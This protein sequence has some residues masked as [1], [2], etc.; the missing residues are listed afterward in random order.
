MIP[1]EVLKLH[2]RT[3]D[4]DATIEDGVLQQYEEAA[5]AYVER[6]TGRYFGPPAERVEILDPSGADVLWLAEA[7]IA[8]PAEGRETVV[9]E[10]RGAE[11]TDL[12]AEE[13]PYELDGR[14]LYREGGWARGR[15]SVR[16]TYWAG[17]SA[18]NEPADIRQAVLEL[19]A[20]YYEERLPVGEMTAEVPHGVREI[21]NRHRR[22][23]V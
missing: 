19:A 18:G 13:T 15:R 14:Q 23:A 6:A 22:I 4:P 2:I 16:V 9:A 20:L 3:A 10:R 7:P 1:L 17:Y 21:I 11:W 12:D 5:V 8:D